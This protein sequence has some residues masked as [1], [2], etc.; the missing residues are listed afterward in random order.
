MPGTPHTRRTNTYA[1]I[2]SG[3]S[4]IGLAIARARRDERA[5]VAILGQDGHAP[6]SS[7]SMNMADE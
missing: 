3:N 2:T 5:S 6:S 1:A 7:V 4:G